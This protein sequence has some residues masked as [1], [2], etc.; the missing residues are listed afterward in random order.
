[1]K[2]NWL[3]AILPHL[4]AVVIF[5]GLA[6]AFCGIHEGKTLNTP[7]MLQ[8][9]GMQKEAKDFYEA[10]GQVPLWTN[11]MFS[12]MPTYVIYTGPSAN[13]VSKINY[14]IMLGLPN[15]ANMLFIAMLGV[16][17]LLSVLGFRYW[18]RILGA[19]AFAFSS[20]SVVIVAEGHITKMMSMAYM[21]P[22]L[23]GIIL[24]YRGRYFTGAALTALATSLLVYNNHLQVVYY[25]LLMVIC[26]VIAAAVHA[27]KEKQLPQFVK[28]SLL[29]A[30]A[31]ALAVMPMFDNLLITKEYTD[32]T[33]RGGKSELTLGKDANHKKSNGLDINYA[34]LWSYGK[35]ETFTVLLPNLVGS[36]SRE[37]LGT[38]SN[39]HQAMVAAGVPAAQADQI[40]TG[41]TW[42]LYWGAQGSTSGPVYFGVIICF[43]FVLSLLIVKSWHK[44]WLL[45][46][47]IF[48]VILSWGS[49]FMVVNEWLFYHLPLYNKFRA[50]AQALIIPQL[51]FVIL[52]CWALQEVFT[53][54]ADKAYL[55]KQLKTATYITG[56][57]V[58]FLGI[59]GSFIFEFS[60]S[61]D[62]M[63]FDQLK[64]MLGS[65]DGARN[66]IR[67]LEKDRS[68]MLL[69]DGIRAV[70]L[71]AI[72]VGII[73]A[74]IKDKLKWQPA[75]IGLC[76]LVIFD[77]FQVDKKFLNSN[78]YVDSM[79]FQAVLAPT[80]ADQQIKQDTDPHYR[81]F[82]LVRND[83]I[84]SYH[85]KSITG[86]SPAKLYIYDDLLNHQIYKN[87]MVVLNMLN[88]KYVIV[89]DQ[90][91]RQPIAQRNPDALGNAWFV[92][93]IQ[94]VPD[95]N[96]EMKALDHFN[97]KDSA[98]ID[99]RFKQELGQLAP[100]ADSAAAIKLTKYS[101]NE[102]Q[103]TAQ[104]SHDGLGVFSEI[105]YPAGWK[106]FIDGKETPILRVN[107]ALRALNIPAGQHK[108]DFKFEPKTY[109]TGQSIAKVTSWLLLI[110]CVAGFAA[111][112]AMDRKQQ[113]PPPPAAKK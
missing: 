41:Q 30:V 59:I 18:I 54:K 38:G 81:V 25:S 63:F 93:G 64:Q 51:T 28:A 52:A 34:Y 58:I 84:T 85:H 48:T 100:A 22:V 91:T 108:I 11:G 109:Y 86:Y 96:S 19:I 113:P 20:Y 75:I 102:L 112:Y 53:E 70:I 8:V 17:V 68:S 67:G 56:G 72:A 105:Y 79:Q 32:Y 45:A 47:T 95:A 12:G 78:N 88:A 103:Y 61:T 31:G 39:F 106:A 62:Q 9:E 80:P 55:L 71:L 24:T 73:W 90:Q 14:G 110:F 87:N 97:P 82:D 21:A 23:A 42:P 69:T 74:F 44:W 99:Q 92:K 10:T 94:W 29:L 66:I 26:L 5:I 83:A 98:V 13:I 1:M 89:P 104:N 50:P 16:Y 35:G 37:K 57:L 46:I 6:I 43:L 101:L 76:L 111:G 27:Y 60:A 77:L 36:S 49:N 15:P 107:Y 3:K 65:E 4:A 2:Q 40:V 7:D 33:M